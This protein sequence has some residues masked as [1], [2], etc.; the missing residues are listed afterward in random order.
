M[1]SGFR[2]YLGFKASL[3]SIRD[4]EVLLIQEGSDY[5]AW[6]QFPELV[7]QGKVLYRQPLANPRPNR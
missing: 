6:Q 5:T 4:A 1:A 2:G 3:E 7:R